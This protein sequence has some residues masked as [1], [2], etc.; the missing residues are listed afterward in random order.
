[1][2]RRRR[3]SRWMLFLLVPVSIATL[4]GVVFL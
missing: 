3:A 4:A 1:V 2:E